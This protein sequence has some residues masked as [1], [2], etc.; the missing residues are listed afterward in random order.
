[1]IVFVHERTISD[2]KSLKQAKIGI[3]AFP[4]AHSQVDIANLLIVRQRKTRFTYS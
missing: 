3:H 4:F 1:M 2:L